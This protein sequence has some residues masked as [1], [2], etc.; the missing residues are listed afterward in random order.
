MLLTGFSIILLM[1]K[2]PATEVLAKNISSLRKQKGWS[3]T[4]LAKKANI[5]QRT[6]S[7]IENP[8]QSGYSPTVDVV[9]RIATAFGIP[10]YHL[11]ILLPLNVLTNKELD[12]IVNNFIVASNSGRDNILRVAE[13]EAK[14]STDTTL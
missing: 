10:C 2:T 7:N 1:T 4:K 8:S 3:Q 12:G 13:M 9:D 5:G 6:V 14:Y 11:F